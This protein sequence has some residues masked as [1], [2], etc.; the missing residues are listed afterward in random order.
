MILDLGHGARMK[1]VEIPAGKF[2]MGSPEREKD[3]NETVAAR[4]RPR[5]LDA[6]CASVRGAVAGK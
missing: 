2:L 6:V 5:Q 1:L 4:Q 3:R